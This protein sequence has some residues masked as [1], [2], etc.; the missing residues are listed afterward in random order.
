MIMMIHHFVLQSPDLLTGGAPPFIILSITIALTVL[1]L[2]V[3]NE[4]D[5]FQRNFNREQEQND[6]DLVEIHSFKVRDY[7]ISILFWL[8]LSLVLTTILFF[9][10]CYRIY[11]FY[12]LDSLNFV[13][14][15]DHLIM[16]I[17]WLEGLWIL[18]ITAYYTYRRELN[19]LFIFR[20][21]EKS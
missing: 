6:P 11:F 15:I 20:D 12:S 9:V 19:L 21:D 16:G 8:P 1:T 14:F 2:S 13:G 3:I 5:K 17:I 4:V 7:P 18:A 10:T